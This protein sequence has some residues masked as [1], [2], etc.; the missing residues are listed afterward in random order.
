MTA[1]H[2]LAPIGLALLF[3][4]ACGGSLS[5]LHAK[6]RPK[7]DGPAHVIV[8]NSSGVV[9]EK[10]YVAKTEAVDRARANGAHPDSEQDQALWGEDQFGNAGLGDGKLYDA[11]NLEADHYDVLVVDHD[12]REQLVKHLTLKPGGKYVLEIGDAWT[13]ARQ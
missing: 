7:G 1:F 13:Q 6:G 5:V 4:L 11:L 10:L 12:H 9:I 3:A 2:R 8:Q